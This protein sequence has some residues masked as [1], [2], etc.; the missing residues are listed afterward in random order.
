MME[1][2]VK[3]SKTLLVKE[4]M[5]LSAFLPFPTTFSIAFLKTWN[6]VVKH[7]MC[8][9]FNSR[10]EVICI[11]QLKPVKFCHFSDVVNYI[12]EVLHV[13]TK[14]EDFTE[15]DLIAQF[16]EKFLCSG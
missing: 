15:C 14:L 5:L 4:E 1:F 8:H 3:L 7:K 13:Q 6:H 11:Q 16:N 2:V 9:T 12:F 10:L